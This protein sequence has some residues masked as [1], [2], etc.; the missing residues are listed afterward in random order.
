MILASVDLIRNSKE[1]IIEAGEVT[2]KHCLLQRS[3]EK[4]TDNQ[5]EVDPGRISNHYPYCYLAPSSTCH[6]YIFCIQ[7]VGYFRLQP[8]MSVTTTCSFMRG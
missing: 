5:F 3:G 6:R 2:D 7:L 8:M 1:R 4:H